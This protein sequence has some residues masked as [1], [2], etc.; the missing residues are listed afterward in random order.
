MKEWTESSSNIQDVEKRE[1]R[2]GNFIKKN[3][4]KFSKLNE[5]YQTTNPNSMNLK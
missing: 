2:E 1:I 4:Q 3:S 5:K